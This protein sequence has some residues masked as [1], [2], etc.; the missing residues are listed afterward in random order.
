MCNTVLGWQSKEKTTN[1]RDADLFDS[2]VL[3]TI[4]YSCAMHKWS[5][6]DPAAKYNPQLLVDT[7]RVC[8]AQFEWVALSER[9]RSQ[10]W[11]DLEALFEKKVHNT[12]IIMTIVQRK[13]FDFL[14]KYNC[15]VGV[16][17]KRNRLPSAFRSIGS[18]IGCTSST[19]QWLCS[20]FSSH[21]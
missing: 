17:S 3:Q 4:F 19:L 8:Q 7:H 21:S 16:T 2:P 1:T 14:F 9:A 10:A 12:F 15:R 6:I 11:K 18:F 20:T 13:A 5:D